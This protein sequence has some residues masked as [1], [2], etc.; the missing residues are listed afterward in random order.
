MH[1]ISEQTEKRQRAVPARHL[2][3]REASVSPELVLVDLDDLALQFEG[4]FWKQ[5][6]V[7]DVV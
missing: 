5:L 3:Q 7:S 6:E 1:F 2:D 4:L